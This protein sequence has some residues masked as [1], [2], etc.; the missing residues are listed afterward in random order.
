[1][2]GCVIQKIKVRQRPAKV[3]RLCLGRFLE[4]RTFA[5]RGLFFSLIAYLYLAPLGFVLGFGRNHFK[6][7]EINHVHSH[8]S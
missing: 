5:A 7:S 3:A 1:M 8:K 6:I 4:R 2:F